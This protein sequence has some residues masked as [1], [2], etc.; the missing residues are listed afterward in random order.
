MRADLVAGIIAI[1]LGG[2][3][4]GSPQPADGR[5][6]LVCVTN[7]T[8]RTLT[9]E[10]RD[11]DTFD[12]F[13]Q[14]SLSPYGSSA[15]RIRTGASDNAL[16]AVVDAVGVSGKWVPPA[17]ERIVLSPGA[18][19]SLTVG[20]D[21]VSRFSHS[22]VNADCRQVSDLRGRGADSTRLNGG[23]PDSTSADSAGSRHRGRD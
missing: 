19:L 1:A 13:G 14:L 5:G 21:G 12:K 15:R 18:P 20:T 3:A 6:T 22:T 11:A 4:T 16:M 23:S 17:F 2:C 8:E 9:V 7:E 10:I